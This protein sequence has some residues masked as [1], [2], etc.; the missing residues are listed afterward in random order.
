MNRTTTLPATRRWSIIQIVVGL[1]GISY[2]FTALALLAAPRW[3]FE[4]IGPFVPYN[5]H[6]EGDLGS[7]LLPLG[8]GLLVAARAPG[9]QRLLI[10]VA[11]AGGLFHAFNHVYDSLAEGASLAHW[12]SDTVPL[13]IFAVLLLL[14]LRPGTLS[15]E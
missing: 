3:F 11:A 10:A 7:F 9:R 8:V 13:L 15:R 6:Y 14:V 5:R 2:I 1:A 12:L 4:N